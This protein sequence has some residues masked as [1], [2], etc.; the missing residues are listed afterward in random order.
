MRLATIRTPQGT[1]AVRVT[2]GHAVELDYPDVGALLRDP[3]WPERAG[4][5]GGPAHPLSSVDYA[6]VVP[7]PR[8]VICVGL[9][10]RTHLA[11]TGQ[12]LPAHPTLFTKFADTLTG[13]RDPIALPTASTEVD[14]EAELGVVIGAPV[15]RA[16]EATAGA[17]IAGY[18]VLNDVSM[19]DWQLRT[20]QWLAGKAF[21]RTTP[22]GPWLTTADEAGPGGREIRCEVDNQ[23]VQRADTADLLF[24]PAEIVAY[25]SQFT[26]LAPGD[27][28]ATGTPG[29]V[30]LARRPPVYLRPGQ[31]LRTVIEGLGECRNPIVADA[32]RNP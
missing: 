26:A 23:V 17:A 11:E 28:I 2:R 15:H 5:V 18:T 20:T 16:D 31:T 32:V 19:R 24:G 12:A 7:L 8:K 27:L 13:A 1:A 30:G 6:P 29:G 22:V 21:D 14:W 10:Y 9:N 3:A 25:V 4:R